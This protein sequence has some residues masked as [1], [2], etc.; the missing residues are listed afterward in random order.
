MLQ[1]CSK[2]RAYCS[3]DDEAMAISTLMVHENGTNGISVTATH[4]LT[5]AR[6]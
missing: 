3:Y 4:V 1:Q 5:L 6:S 2:S